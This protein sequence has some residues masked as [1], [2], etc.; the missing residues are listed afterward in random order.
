[1]YRSSDHDP[2]VHKLEQAFSRGIVQS[3]E[4]ENV[5]RLIELATITLDAVHAL[6]TTYTPA[7]RRRN[8]PPRATAALKVWYDENQ[9]DPYPSELQKRELA[10]IAGIKVQQVS[11]WFSNTRNRA[12]PGGK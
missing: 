12:S 1:M 10:G 2:G 8:L 11:N 4:V 5:Q 3:Q 7:R 9:H 6:K